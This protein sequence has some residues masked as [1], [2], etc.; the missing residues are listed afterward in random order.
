MKWSVVT[1][2]RK[3][4]KALWRGTAETPAATPAEEAERDREC[5]E[6]L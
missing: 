6:N 2:K 3:D 1:Q 5:S 4:A